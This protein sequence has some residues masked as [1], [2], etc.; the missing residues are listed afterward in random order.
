MAQDLNSNLAP[1]TWSSAVASEPEREAAGTRAQARKRRPKP[2]PTAKNAD[3][4]TSETVEN[5]PHTLDHF[6]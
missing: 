6:A 4:D 3:A 2:P 5:P 1:V